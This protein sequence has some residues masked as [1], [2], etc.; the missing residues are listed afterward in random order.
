MVL[1]ITQ[2]SRRERIENWVINYYD[3][4]KIVTLLILGVF[5]FICSLEG[6]R[7]GF[8]LVGS[9]WQSYLLSMIETRLA[10][11]T[12][13]A[14][15]ML[16]TS[17]VQ[18]S[19]AVIATTMVSMAGLVASGL[20]LSSTISFGIPIILGANVGTTITNTIVAL[21]TRKEEFRSVIPAVLI[22]DIYEFLSISVFFILEIT[23]GFLSKIT[24][25]LASFFID[26]LKFEAIFVMFQRSVIDIL[27]K[28]PITE[29]VGEIF[30]SFLGTR[31]GGI[32][33]SITWFGTILL[34]LYLIEKNL[35]KLIKTPGARDRVLSAFKSPT[36]SFTTG[37]TITWMVG[38]SSVGT[39]LAIPF[40]AEKVV[41]LERVYP[42]MLGCNM[43][44]AVDLSQIYSYISGGIVGMT[45]GLAHVILNIFGLIVWLCTPL[46]VV[47]LRIANGI[48]RFIISYR[49][50]ALLLVGYAFL[51]FFVIPLVII[52]VL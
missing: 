45:L 10:P 37:F 26:V 50:S 39:S 47:P 43:A 25:S 11:L 41:D 40:L 21:G 52:F 13:L 48:G 33:L 42:Y 38:S 15:G 16:A 51:L 2:K 49:Y 31:L 27:I 30:S 14:L 44:T 7:C 22:D 5:L 3:R 18:S 35:S 29:P 6:L 9:E 36:R 28:G 20:P 46:K 19:S 17:L 23:T 34:S 32:L 24:T 4:L 8:K 12:G 1:Q